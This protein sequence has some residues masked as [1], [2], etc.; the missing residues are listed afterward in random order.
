MAE[1]MTIRAVVFQDR[2]WW[3]AECLESDLSSS[4]RDRKEL[5]RKLTLQLRLQITLDLAK[6]RKPFDSLP[7]APQKFWDMYSAGSAS[8]EMLPI[9]GSWL[10]LF[11]RAWRWRPGVQAKL[12]LA[13]A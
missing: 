5:I 6:G 2:G 13:T 12:T 4:A 7:R 10:G 1:P 9:R 3:V 11:F 8:E